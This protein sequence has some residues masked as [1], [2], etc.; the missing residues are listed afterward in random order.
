PVAVPLSFPRRHFAVFSDPCSS[1]SFPARWGCADSPSRT[2]PVCIRL[3]V[4]VAYGREGRMAT[5]CLDHNGVS[6]CRI[7]LGA[8]ELVFVTEVDLYHSSHWVLE[9]F[10]NA[11]DWISILSVIR[12]FCLH[13]RRL[14]YVLGIW[15]RTRSRYAVLRRLREGGC[16]AKACSAWSYPGGQ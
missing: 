1:R 13:L 10:S 16:L 3:P 7:L 14:G 11:A 2:V 15:Q 5:G 12:V 8:V 9:G 6:I 4:P